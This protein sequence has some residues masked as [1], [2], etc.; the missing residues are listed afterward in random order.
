MEGFRFHSTFQ[1]ISYDEVKCV[2]RSRS[3]AVALPH[4][5]D[6]GRA[7]DLDGLNLVGVHERGGHGLYLH[8]VLRHV[9]LKYRRAGQ[10]W[11]VWRFWRGLARFGEVI[12]SDVRGSLEM[13]EAR[14]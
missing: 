13:V 10:T 11:A 4:L 12:S 1:V 9:D 2:P 8:L 5:A 7:G 3:F 6:V 14:S